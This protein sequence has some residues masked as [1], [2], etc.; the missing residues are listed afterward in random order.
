MSIIVIDMADPPDL[1]REARLQEQNRSQQ[2]QFEL[3]QGSCT[4]SPAVPPS[5][6][7]YPHRLPAK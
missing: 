2:L 4:I 5:R 7:L 1:G 3:P 6:R